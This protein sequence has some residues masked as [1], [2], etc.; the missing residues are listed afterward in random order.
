MRAGSGRHRYRKT[1]MPQSGYPV[2]GFFTK[3]RNFKATIVI[4][5][6]KEF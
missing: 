3:K 5:L 2:F 4:D 6:R 1:P